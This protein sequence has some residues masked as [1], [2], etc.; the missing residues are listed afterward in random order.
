M[1]YII[2]NNIQSII[3]QKSITFHRKTN[4]ILHY[5]YFNNLFLQINMQFVF[6]PSPSSKKKN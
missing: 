4:P 1:C 5:Q 6:A 2:N 3:L